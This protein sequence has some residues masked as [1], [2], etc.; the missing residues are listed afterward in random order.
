MR[1]QNRR[2]F[3]AR[4]LVQLAY[5]QNKLGNLWVDFL[6]LPPFELGA[7]SCQYVCRLGA[8]GWVDHRPLMRKRP[9]LPQQRMSRRQRI[10]L[11][12][13]GRTLASQRSHQTGQVFVRI[14]RA[15]LRRHQQVAK[16]FPSGQVGTRVR[17]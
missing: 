7:H 8:I 9:K 17:L 16:R 3:L 12:L 2:S 15:R 14:G 5:H 6:P 11:Q 13:A 4:D 10:E 1:E